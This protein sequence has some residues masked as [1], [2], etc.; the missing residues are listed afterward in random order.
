[1]TY[2]RRGNIPILACSHYPPCHSYTI[3]NDSSK[4]EKNSLSNSIHPHKSLCTSPSLPLTVQSSLTFASSQ[5]CVHLHRPS[6]C[7]LIA[8]G[9]ELTACAT[10]CRTANLDAAISSALLPSYVMKTS[11][12]LK[13]AMSAE[14]GKFDRR[15]TVRASSWVGHFPLSP[16]RTSSQEESS[17][18]PSGQGRLFLPTSRY[19]RLPGSCQLS[20]MHKRERAILQV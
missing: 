10:S 16:A 1:M 12:G 9:P 13:A 15:L 11:I 7:C 6:V 17:I 2:M 4:A 18:R 3:S 20:R 14:D 5:L 8:S 19:L